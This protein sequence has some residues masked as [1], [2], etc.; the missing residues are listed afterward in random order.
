MGLETVKKWMDRRMRENTYARHHHNGLDHLTPVGVIINGSSGL[1]ERNE[2]EQPFLGRRADFSKNDGFP[3][4]VS[5][6]NGDS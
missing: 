6:T 3:E 4:Y 1:F 5:K 2:V